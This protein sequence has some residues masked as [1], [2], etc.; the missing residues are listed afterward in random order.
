MDVVGMQQMFQVQKGG[1]VASQVPSYC[2]DSHLACGEGIWSYKRLIR[3]WNCPFEH[4]YTKHYFE[5]NGFKYTYVVCLSALVPW[6]WCWCPWFSQRSLGSASLHWV[7]HLTRHQNHQMD[8]GCPFSPQRRSTLLLL[9]Q[10]LSAC[11]TGQHG[12]LALQLSQDCP[13]NCCLI[14]ILSPTSALACHFGRMTLHLH[15]CEWL[16]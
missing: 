6:S 2:Q 15:C 10:L 1:T 7:Y 12:R 5:L 16:P 8:F 3:I 13:H 14:E 9:F 4:S 11:Q